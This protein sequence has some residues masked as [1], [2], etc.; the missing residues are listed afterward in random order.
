M[1]GERLDRWLEGHEAEML[2]FAQELLRIPSV[3]AEGRPGQPFGPGPAQALERALAEGERLGFAVRN[4]EGYAGHVE[5]GG[6][7]ELVGVL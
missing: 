1:L 5:A 7:G 4:V 6:G 3:K 2:R